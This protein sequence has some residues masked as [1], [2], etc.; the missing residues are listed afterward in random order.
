MLHILLW[1][2]KII[3]IILA[4]VVGLILL[5]AVCILLAPLRYQV[6]ADGKL[7]AEE[8]LHAK[9]KIFWLLHIVSASFIYPQAAYIKVKL[10]GIPIIDMSKD[11][12]KQKEN[13]Q[14]ESTADDSPKYAAV[15]ENDELKD[16]LK[17]E[18]NDE[19]KDE[20]GEGKTEINVK[21]EEAENE[22]RKS[23]A[24]TFVEA[25]LRFCKRLWRAFQ[26]IE[27]TIRK[28]CDKIRKITADI[29]Y[30]IQ[31][32]KSDVFREALETAK[33]QLLRIFR[34][35]RPKKCI[36]HLR[37]GTGDPAS[38]GQMMA[39]YGILYPFIGNAVF[40]QADFEEKVIEG[41]L[42]IKGKITILMLLISAFRLYTDKK[43]RQLLRLIK[44][45]EALDGR[46]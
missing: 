32:L 9:I 37:A 5:L 22:N 38:T 4:V 45:E 16:E 11:R 23:K 42:M 35:L 12:K 10:F 17:D 40:L 26:N 30:Y 20:K 29:E 19:L 41:D 33:K 43:T 3:G 18:L 15:S 25:V 14:K 27:Y 13:P 6:S 24:E 8:P 44:R 36:I 34:T 46:E 21:N 1:I 2:L 31:I 7:G 39:L 28:I